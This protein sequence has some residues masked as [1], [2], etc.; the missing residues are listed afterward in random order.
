MSTTISYRIAT[1]SDREGLRVLL[2]NHFY[3]HEPFYSG[4]I[5]RDPIDEDIEIT[6]DLVSNGTSFVAVENEIIIGASLTGVNDPFTVQEM[7]EE[8]KQTKNPNWAQLLRSAAQFDV[9]ADIF[10]R[11]NV[12]KVFHVY[13][14]V[15]DSNYRGR[16]IATR[17]VERSLELA[18][19]LGHKMC[20]INC[21]NIYTARIAN[22]CEMECISEVSM[23]NIKNERG[24]RLI[25]PPHPHIHIKYYAKRLQ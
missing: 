25:K 23:E 24:E 18:S 12:E 22:K 11:F 3:P 1:S 2:N 8:A 16:S 14:L 5:N 6:L 19:S 4:W 21:S 20:S 13:S 17:L 9:D 15:V 10:R 7:I